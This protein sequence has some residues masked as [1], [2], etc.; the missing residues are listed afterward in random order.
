MVAPPH[1]CCAGFGTQSITKQHCSIKA[2]LCH[3]WRARESLRCR[4]LL[5]QQLTPSKGRR[6]CRAMGEAAA[7]AKHSHQDPCL[8]LDAFSDPDQPV[9][10]VQPRSGWA[11]DGN[12]FIHHKGRY[13]MCASSHRL[14][15]QLS[16]MYHA[17]YIWISSFGINLGRMPD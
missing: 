9:Y 14:K 16:S 17:F 12:G 5:L 13:H 4:P 10:H 15:L 3:P 2:H 11:N 7:V 6:N 8:G 1:T